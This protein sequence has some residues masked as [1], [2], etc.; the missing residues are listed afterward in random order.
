M[1]TGVERARRI[2][3][4]LKAVARTH[5]RFD[6]LV[7]GRV[8]SMVELAAREKVDERYIRRVLRLATLSPE[9]V[10]SIVGGRQPPDL[11]L[12]M[13]LTRHLNLSLD[14]AAQQRAFGMDEVAARSVAASSTV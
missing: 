5:Q 3:H 9:V 6:D 13:L 11:S 8:S 14:W 1:A 4:L 12:Q 2:L 7:S 10:E